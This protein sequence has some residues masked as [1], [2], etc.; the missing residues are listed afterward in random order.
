MFMADYGWLW[1]GKFVGCG[2]CGLGQS[3]C[4]ARR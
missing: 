1:V 2:G 4:E 3:A